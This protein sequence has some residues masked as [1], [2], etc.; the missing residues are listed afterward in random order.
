MMDPRPQ[1][2]DPEVLL[3]ED[4]FLRRLARGLVRDDAS[5]D[6]LAQNVWLA[7]LLRPIEA[8][9]PKAM[10]STIAFRLAG[11]TRR[12]EQRRWVHEGSRP[13]PKPVPTPA[14]VLERE[15]M[16]SRLVRAVC[17]LEPLLRDVVLLRFF[18]GLPPR[19]I[20]ARI[21]A[22]VETVRS[23]QK[24]A[25]ALLREQLDRE[26]PSGRGSWVAL[27]GAIAQ[28]HV[29]A[30]PSTMGI[31]GATVAC[32]AAA[33]LWMVFGV[34]GQEQLAPPPQSVAVATV[35]Q[36]GV[37][38]ASALL[39]SDAPQE[40]NSRIQVATPTSTDATSAADGAGGPANPA[41]A[42]VASWPVAFLVV[43][44]DGRAIEGAEVRLYEATIE[45]T[46]STVRMG[47]DAALPF[48]TLVSGADGRASGHSGHELCLA[49][50]V[51]P[52]VPQRRTGDFQILRDHGADYRVV[53][54]APVEVRGRALDAVGQP[55]AGA[56]VVARPRPMEFARRLGTWRPEP[57]VADEDGAFSLQLLPGFTYELSAR[58]DD[59]ATPSVGVRPSAH[60]AT[61]VVLQSSR[62][63]TVHGVVI[64]EAGNA[65]SGA[66][67]RVLR[68]S[69]PSHESSLGRDAS[70]GGMA[71]TSV[72][73]SFSVEMPRTGRFQLVAKARGKAAS[74]VRE[75]TT[76]HAN[77][78]AHVT[79]ALQGYASI[80]GRVVSEDGMPMVG[81]LVAFVPQADPM[82]LIRGIRAEER[83]G[84]PLSVRTDADGAFAASVHPAVAWNLRVVPNGVANELH[85]EHRDVAPGNSD[86]VVRVPDLALRG[87]VVRGRVVRS[88]GGAVPPYRLRLMRYESA[89]HGSGSS[90]GIEFDG[91]RF[92]T[93]PLPLGSACEVEVLFLEDHPVYVASSAQRPDV[94]STLRFAPCRSGR[95]VLDRATVECELVVRGYGRL[96]A[97]VR[98]AAGQLV[99]GVELAATVEGTNYHP[100]AFSDPSGVAQF[101]RCAPGSNEVT[102]WR[103]GQRIGSGTVEVREG[104]ESALELT[105][106]LPS[107]R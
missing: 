106:G 42:R 60:D 65:V 38:R 62:R 89:H 25:F 66:T 58:R 30:G 87:C 40:G 76:D 31:V 80:G 45:A 53:L 85:F 102:A 33:T 100:R 27:V 70:S 104:E 64:D 19:A 24:R 18:E 20:A 9:S 16:R 56:Q 8:L 51:D 84:A 39:A 7:A 68:M 59:V 93:E 21:G 98:D 32:A 44:G 3:A 26:T 77:P 50:A 107:G 71:T 74:E 48:A 86:V 15:E 67:V 99:P 103:D 29:A 34:E 28:G 61:P 63:S 13:Q 12:G 5:A 49:A 101:A 91:D 96:R 92:W 79:L 72:D 35:D 105:L 69:D 41:S 43:D 36:G 54:E 1:S 95:I 55:L 37:D 78:F 2:L 83:Y 88:D 17:A 4:A 52:R 22:P 23:R 82:M 81:A 10:L 46:G 75:V 94:S 73:G 97:T 6:D 57:T 11:K 47:G 90:A 14:E